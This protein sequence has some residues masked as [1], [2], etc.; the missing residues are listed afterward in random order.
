MTFLWKKKLA[1]QYLIKNFS[2]ML[3]NMSNKDRLFPSLCCLSLQKVT[4]KFQCPVTR[5]VFVASS[6]SSH[7]KLL[8]EVLWDRLVTSEKLCFPFI[9][10]PFFSQ[11]PGSRSEKELHYWYSCLSISAV[12]MHNELKMP[13]CGSRNEWKGLEL[14]QL[15]TFTLECSNKGLA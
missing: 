14:V 15:L 3:G 11:I 12:L 13:E 7:H 8:M 4:F 5:C 6:A 10:L 1:E 2:R 9:S